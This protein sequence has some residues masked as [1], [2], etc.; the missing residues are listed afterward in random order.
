M[1][2]LCVCVCVCTN[3][4]TLRNRREPRAIPLPIPTKYMY[5]HR[6]A[7]H[8]RRQM[9]H[10]PSFPLGC[11]NMDTPLATRL[12]SYRLTLKSRRKRPRGIVSQD[13]PSGSNMV[14]RGHGDGSEMRRIIFQQCVFHV[15]SLVTICCCC[16][17][18][19]T[20]MYTYTTRITLITKYKVETES[21]VA[22][23]VHKNLLQAIVWPLALLLI[24][25]VIKTIPLFN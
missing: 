4:C 18:M 3:I 7:G 5:R 6:I 11:A 22:D 17:I 24:V 10:P 1:R 13:L 23:C 12:E 8:L 19:L 20:I 14:K 2:S 15:S 16:F 21:S 25:H 9:K